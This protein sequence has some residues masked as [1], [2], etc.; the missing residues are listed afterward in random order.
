M[1]ATFGQDFVCIHVTILLL[2]SFISWWFAS[3]NAETFRI[4]ALLCAFPNVPVLSPLLVYKECPYH[5]SEKINPPGII[6]QA[7]Q[8]I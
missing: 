3:V 6:T 1:K 7:Y 5:R 2:R 8:Q 4:N